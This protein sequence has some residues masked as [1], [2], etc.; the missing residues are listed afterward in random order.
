MLL[1][2]LVSTCSGSAKG[3]GSSCAYRAAPC[4]FRGL[5]SDTNGF[6][7]PHATSH[8]RYCHWGCNDTQP[9]QYVRTS[10]LMRNE[11]SGRRRPSVQ[12]FR[13]WQRDAGTTCCTARHDTL[14]RPTQQAAQA[15]TARHAGKGTTRGEREPL[16]AFCFGPCQPMRANA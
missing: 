12:S 1:F 3:L 2:S 11:A 7:L 15:I 9:N 16:F 5:A 8:C 6:H 4:P 10:Y 14:C 13:L